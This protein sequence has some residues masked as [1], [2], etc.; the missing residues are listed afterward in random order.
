M[1][2]VLSVSL[3][4]R[5]CVMTPMQKRRREA[6]GDSRDLTLAATRG[7]GSVRVGLAPATSGGWLAGIVSPRCA[8]SVCMGHTGYRETA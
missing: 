5:M 7:L 1:A 4:Y 2:A 8:Y 3:G 6:F